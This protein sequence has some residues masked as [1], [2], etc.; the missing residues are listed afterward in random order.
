MTSVA[1]VKGKFPSQMLETA[2][3]LIE[4]TDLIGP[5]DRVLIKP[6][7]V[8]ARQPSTG[9]TTDS[10]V[11]D[12]IIEFVKRCGVRDIIVG[13]GG[14]GDT[15]KAFDI[16]G[17]REV[18][19]YHGVRLVN[20]N[21]DIRVNVKVPQPLALKEVGVAKTALEST[22]I[23]NVPTL[24]VHHIAVVT[25][26]MKNLMGLILPKSIMHGQINQKIVDLASIFKDKTKINVVDAL[27]G[28]EF[29]ETRGSPVEMNLIIAGQD[30][31]AVDA[32]GTAVM[33][34]DPLTVK[35]LRIAEEIGL[36]VSSLEEITVLGE[37]INKV[38]KRF[39]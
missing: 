11:I 33:G 37:N 4:A 10:R 13:E 25:L 30:M 15:E 7:Y 5:E 36:G 18:V 22:C 19:T 21:R 34:I 35:Y 27:V 16:V 28:A 26:S 12:G 1:I 3:K 17:I 6:N 14:S 32:V 29:D 8:R 9:I 24:K 38:K 39:R 31:V 23:I 20:L 2:L